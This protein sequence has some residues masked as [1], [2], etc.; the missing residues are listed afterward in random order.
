L[1]GKIDIVPGF[2]EMSGLYRQMLR[3]RLFLGAIKELWE[4]G[5][6]SG[7]MHLEIGE[8]AVAAGVVMHLVEGDAMALDHRGTPPLVVR[9]VDLVLLLKEMLGLPGGLCGGKGGHMHFFSRRHMAAASGIVGASAPLACG[10]AL[11]GQYLKLET[12]SVAFFGEGAMNQ[13]MVMEA[14]NL[15]RIWNLQ[16]LFVCK[17]N[18]WAITTRS[19]SVTAG[20]LLER[21]ASFGLA[22]H[23][24][25]GG[26]VREV[27][28][29]AGD[30][31]RSV[32]SGAGPAFLLV[33]VT[34]PEGH[35]LGDPVLRVAKS[36]IKQMAQL[37]GPLVRS[38]TRSAGA[39]LAERRKGL[40]TIFSSILKAAGDA[41]FKG[42][43][44]LSRERARL[45]E[46]GFPVESL[47]RE[48]REEVEKAVSD[49]LEE[50][51]EGTK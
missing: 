43:D 26:D 27:W 51:G 8:E 39:S 48:V 38:A 36:P 3:C 40:A 2:F 35:M 10:F 29:V 18:G 37:S 21:A 14:L 32:R 25:D 5:A 16:A 30:A 33:R 50:K 7:E 42:Q 4:R 1:E 41:K 6:I 45:K 24:A 31:I 11:A 44:P 20:N 12:V 17:D 19:E 47:E 49:A 23:E 15:S 46:E 34:R 9:G 22:V 13:G 28:K